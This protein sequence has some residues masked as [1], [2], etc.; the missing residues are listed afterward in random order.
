LGAGGY[1]SAKNFYIS[2]TGNASFKG[3]LSVTDGSI[4][5]WVI[6]PNRLESNGGLIKL[7]AADSGTGFQ[8]GWIELGSGT[9]LYNKGSQ[10]WVDY[11]GP[12]G[13][14]TYREM[15][16]PFLDPSLIYGVSSAYSVRFRTQAAG[17]GAILALA[18]S[19]GNVSLYGN[20]K[21]FAGGVN[22]TSDR[23]LKDK[24]KEL[25]SKFGIEFL[26]KLKPV[27]YVF[28]DDMNSKKFGFVAQEV[29]ASMAE[30]G[31]DVSNSSLVSGD[32]NKPEVTMH[33]SYIE[34]IAPLVKAVQQL[35]EK[36]ENLEMYISGSINK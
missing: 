26:N 8:Y 14:W 36:V 2:S 1:I 29:T 3:T 12:G 27:E 22:L 9:Q 30:Y 15:S 21:V 18:A 33:L 17:E 28:K 34:L 35:S 16:M 13:A 10:F 5:G 19:S 7:F 31:M 20:G 6:A 11:S 25:D 24:I 23:R 4:G 32:I